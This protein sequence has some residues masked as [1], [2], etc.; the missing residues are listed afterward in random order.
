M[1]TSLRSLFKDKKV[2]AAPPQA[3][4]KLGRPP[5]D[6]PTFEALSEEFQA[7]V[8]ALKKQRSSEL[9]EEVQQLT[10]KYQGQQLVAAEVVA[11]HQGQQLVAVEVAEQA[12]SSSGQMQLALEDEVQASSNSGQ[13]QLVEVEANGS[14][15]AAERSNDEWRS[16]CKVW[17]ALGGKSGRLGG[18]P[19]K[20]EGQWVKAPGKK[21]VRDETFGP[22]Q[23]LM[24]CAMM[25][26]LES[27]FEDIEAL[28]KH[29][30]SLTGRTKAQVLATWNNEDKWKR[31]CDSSGV[32]K[33]GLSKN[34]AHLP[35]YL[36]KRSRGDGKV[37]RAGG[38]GR[39][40]ETAFLYPGLK[41]WFDE[42]RSTGNYVDKQDLV[43]EFQSIAE[44]FLSRR[45][46]RVCL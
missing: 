6:K 44:E 22:Q 13:M 26:K 21:R 35:G 37:S 34:Q 11:K 41:V 17:G 38:A 19:R 45:F 36:R 28:A 3:K 24:M 20:P 9:A 29:M 14:M 5:K 30:A 31:I 27:Q 23:K 1:Q 33:S 12:S 16:Q 42:M 46:R 18:R 2:E 7:E 43:L 40:S 32:S 4:R 39:K 25:H 10:A 15:V 8:R